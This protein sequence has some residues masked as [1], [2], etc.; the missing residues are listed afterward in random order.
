M[1]RKNRSIAVKPDHDVAETGE[2]FSLYGDHPEWRSMGR[3]LLDLGISDTEI[4]YN[5]FRS[6]EL[7]SAKTSLEEYKAIHGLI[8]EAGRKQ[9]D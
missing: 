5:F 1:A 9:N 6:Q 8:L 3:K 2:Y 7:I 4:A